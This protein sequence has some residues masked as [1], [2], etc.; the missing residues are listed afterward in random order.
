MAEGGG[1]TEPLMQHTED[2][3]TEEDDETFKFS[4]EKE[5]QTSTPKNPGEIIEMQTRLQEQSGLP[6]ISYQETD[7]GGTATTEEIERRLK[8]LRD[9][10]TGLLDLSKIDLQKNIFSPEDMQKEIQ[11]VKN[12]IKIRYPN[13]KLD[14]LII[15]FSEKNLNQIVVEGPS[16]GETQIILKDGSGL[17][18]VFLNKTFV[19]KALRKPAKTVIK[20][21]SADILNRQKELESERKKKEQAEKSLR[22]QTEK[23]MDLN[24]ELNK[25]KAK[26]EQMKDLPEYDEE[27]KRKKQLTKNLEKDL[28]IATQERKE[29]EK[30]AKNIADQDQKYALLEASLEE[31]IKKQKRG[32]RKAQPNKTVRRP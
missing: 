1:E 10:R 6:D 5:K 29:L 14:T 8:D 30:K 26:I 18:K 16:G 25:E 31:E 21:T 28:K 23:I 17:A 27:I 2:K 32:G 22:E 9:S 3:K 11:K 19:K 12:F 20:N 15:R 24:D 13:A 4:P 7:F